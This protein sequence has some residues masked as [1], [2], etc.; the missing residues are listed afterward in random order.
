M[1]RPGGLLA[2]TVDFWP[3][4]T[5]HNPHLG[6]LRCYNEEMLMDLVAMVAEDFS[7]VGPYDYEHVEAYVNDYTFA[8]L[9]LRKSS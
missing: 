1:V 3:D 6:Q 4:G 8:S 7:P 5:R 2:I 9:V